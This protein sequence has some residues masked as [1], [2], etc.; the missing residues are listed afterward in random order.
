MAYQGLARYL[1]SEQPVYAL[2]NHEIGGDEEHVD[3]TI[4]QM[5]ARYVDAIQTV[6]A[7]G[8][9]MVGG[10]SMG[11][12]LAMEMAQQLVLRS[13]QVALVA[14]LDTHAQ[15]RPRMQG[16]PMHAA[17]AID[18]LMYASVIASG[19]GRGFEAPVSGLENVDAQ[20]QIAY[21]FQ[22]LR[23]YEL[24]PASLSLAAF[25][26]AL[27]TFRRNVDALEKYQ[28]RT[29]EGR[30]LLLRASEVSEV[31][32][33]TAGAIYDDPA[34]GWQA[35]CTQPLLVESV[36]GDHESMN[37]EPNVRVVGA[38]LQR[39]IDETLGAGN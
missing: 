1:R 22:K 33:R 19:Q 4:E 36:P 38:V 30:V 27:M 31:M 32:K 12:T 37:L 18:L 24:V 21:I 25:R 17:L 2:Q 14:L 9:Y 39:Y 10:A 34:C 7:H 28:P 23:E 26:A 8:P 29:Y 20:S 35:Y 5:A 13:E 15:V 11:G 6:Q 16:Q 3:A